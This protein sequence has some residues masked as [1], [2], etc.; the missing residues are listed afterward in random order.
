MTVGQHEVLCATLRLQLDSNVRDLVIVAGEATQEVDAE[1]AGGPLHVHSNGV[2]A[3]LALLPDVLYLSQ[4]VTHGD[5]LILH[6]SHWSRTHTGDA[7]QVFS[8][9]TDTHRQLR[10]HKHRP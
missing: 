2:G 3:G 9:R 10:I 6:T 7:F 1:G 4:Q 8:A 5:H